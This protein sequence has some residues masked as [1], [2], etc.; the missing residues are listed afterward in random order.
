MIINCTVDA[1]G[2]KCVLY[3]DTTSQCFVYRTTN[4][5]TIEAGLCLGAKFIISTLYTNGFR[6]CSLLLPV[7]LLT[8]EGS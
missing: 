6:F 7:I 3:L 2:L 1:S 4:G 8:I 5:R